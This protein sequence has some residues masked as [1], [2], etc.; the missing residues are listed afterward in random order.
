MDDTMVQ[1]DI[2]RKEIEFEYWVDNETDDD[3]EFE[4]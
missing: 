3:E 4:W 2:T 1:S